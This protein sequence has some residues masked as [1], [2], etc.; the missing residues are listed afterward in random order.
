MTSQAVGE[1]RLV[2]LERRPSL[3]VRA[4]NSASGAAQPTV[5]AASA[6][7][8]KIALFRRLF[9]GRPD[10]F[11]IRWENRKT[12]KVGYAPACANEW[13]KGICGKPQVKCGEC[14][15]QSFFPVSG[16]VIE[17]HLRGGDKE[18]LPASD[19]V[20]GVYPLLLDG[21]CWFLAADFDKENWAADA[22]AILETCRAK[23]I[24][25]ALERS[26]SGN[27]GH[28][29]IFFPNQSLHTPLANSEPRSS[30]KQ[31]SAVRRSVLGRMTDSFQVRIRCRLAA[32]AI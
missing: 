5:T 18:R 20:A 23:E 24:P 21:T 31:W 30:Q 8:D 12:G 17:R 16:E 15:N 32:S 1:P 3:I 27:G 9:A 10:V 11:P 6:T 29:W 22:T 26:R 4:G 14:P 28:I 2:E 19:F 13:A 25:A 7:T